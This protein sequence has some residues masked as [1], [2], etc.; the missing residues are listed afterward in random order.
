MLSY[1]ALEKNGAT[2][3][4]LRYKIIAS[5]YVPYIDWH[6]EHFSCFVQGPSPPVMAAQGAGWMSFDCLRPIFTTHNSS[7][8]R[9]RGVLVF[10][11]SGA[12]LSCLDVLSAGPALSSVLQSIDLDIS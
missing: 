5:L 4:F 6:L 1:T 7:V 10:Q 3:N 11:G 8:L 12:T 9:G 2:T